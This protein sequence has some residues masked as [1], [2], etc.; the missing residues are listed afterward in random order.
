MPAVHPALSG[1]YPGSRCPGWR[2]ERYRQARDVLVADLGIDPG[3]ELQQL[4]RRL[5]QQ[6][7]ALEPTWS[8]KTEAPDEARAEPA[9]DSAVPAYQ[10]REACVDADFGAPAPPAQL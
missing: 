10:D 6:D 3:P 5:L 8:A 2:R 7:T 4:E 9:A 1:N